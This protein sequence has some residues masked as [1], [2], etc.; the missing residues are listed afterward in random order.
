[1]YLA[2]ARNHGQNR[3]DHHDIKGS[4]SRLD[5]VHAA[6][7]EVKLRHLDGWNAS[8]RRVASV[9]RQRLA[10][11]GLEAPAEHPDAEH[12]YHLF[13]VTVDRRDE[14]QRHLADRGI[15]TGIHYPIPIHQQ[16]V[17]RALGRDGRYPIV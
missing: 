11:A 3:K 17:Y 4:N 13:V 14:L 15:E 8:R 5:T 12:V 2:K 6:I 16:G 7:L 9:Y 10:E 1:S